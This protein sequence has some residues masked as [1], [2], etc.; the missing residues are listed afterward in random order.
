M[1]Q[2][3]RRT[4]LDACIGSVAQHLLGKP[5]RKLSSRTQ[6][7]FGTHG[8]IAVEIGGDRIGSWYDHENKQGGGV[9]DLI[10]RETQCKKRDAIRWLQ[11]NG[12][13]DTP[14]PR[15]Q[16]IA[17]YD[18]RDPDGALLF[19]VLRYEPKD[20]RHRQPDKKG[21]WLWN[22]KGI[23]PIP[24]CLP[25][26]LRAAHN[27]PVFV[28]EGE[29]DCDNVHKQ[30]L[31]ATTNP[32]GA[33][34]WLAGMSQYLRDK[35]AIILPH[36]DEA[37]ERHA[38]DVARKLTGV[39]RSIRILRLPGLPPKGDVS[40]WLSM[41]GTADE[42]QRLS[43][44]AP[45]Q[46]DAG[47]RDDYADSLIPGVRTF[48][49]IEEWAKREVPEPDRLLGDLVTTTT[50][51]FLVGRTGLG[52]TLLVMGLA[53]GMANGEGFLH[54]RS[55]RPA[56][57]LVIDGEMPGELIKAR[58]IDALGRAGPIPPGNLV[59]YSRDAEDEF[60]RLFPKLGRFAPLNSEEGL[61]FLSALIAALGGVD[62]VIF[63]NVMSLLAGDQKDEVSWSE[64]LPLV[65]YLTSR[66]I[67]QIW[68]DHTGHNSDRQYGSST[69]AWCFDGVGIMTPLPDGQQQKEEVAFKLSFEPPGKARRRTPDNWRDFETCTI[70]LRDGRWTSEEHAHAPR[71]AK[72]S[73]TA[74][75]WHEALFDA[76]VIS[77]TPSRTTRSAWYAEAVR[78]GLAEPIGP[79]DSSSVKDAKKKKFRKYL[80]ELKVARLIG[81]DGE[82]VN[83][84]RSPRTRPA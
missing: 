57:V 77:N 35:E 55:A 84:L 19:Q 71:S 21:G 36:H 41:G 44:Q 83:D 25:E 20:F 42:L 43:A 56:R 65:R 1:T 34:K 74:N 28:C 39:A 40:D 78:L 54:W 24:Y 29:K 12:F 81:V 79:A 63:D 60:A 30:G 69:K 51:I 50:R 37:G 23:V 14:R 15:R 16:V 7:R 27:A 58:S 18:Y 8:S 2:P 22:I 38:A 49:S 52:K 73:P 64:V 67:G 48:L 72:L 6:L 80:S 70:R 53:C 46:A 3:R 47:G 76:L 62:V 11:T 4:D 59:I 9:L 32:G 13:I 31:I 68:M 66:R 17:E 75:A 5:N 33:G 61:N 10:S 82:T 45:L 26:L